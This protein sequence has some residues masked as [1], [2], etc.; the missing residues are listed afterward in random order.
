MNKEERINLI[1]ALIEASNSFH[2][3]LKEL[4]YV[5]SYGLDNSKTGSI[6]RIGVSERNNWSLG[7]LSI[8]W[9]I[10]SEE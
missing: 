4:G 6:R 1:N 9:K 10:N 7:N 2:N 5:V 8:I 3:T